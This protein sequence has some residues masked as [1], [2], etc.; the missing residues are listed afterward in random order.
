M[1]C[2]QVVDLGTVSVV[3]MGNGHLVYESNCRPHGRLNARSEVLCVA[4][5]VELGSAAALTMGGGYFGFET[6]RAAYS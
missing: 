1:I 6:T 5:T 3:T 2:N 4:Q